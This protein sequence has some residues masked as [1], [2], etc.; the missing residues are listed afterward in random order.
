MSSNDQ[1]CHTELPLTLDDVSHAFLRYSRHAKTS[2]PHTG[3]FPKSKLFAAFTNQ[4]DRSLHADLSHTS[5]IAQSLFTL[6]PS[7]TLPLTPIETLWYSQLPS[8][9]QPQSSTCKIAPL[10]PLSLQFRANRLSLNSLLLMGRPFLPANFLTTTT[11]PIEYLRYTFHQFFTNI[12]GSAASVVSIQALLLAVGLSAVQATPAAAAL[13]WVLKDL[14]GNIGGSLL[15]AKFSQQ[16]DLQPR[17]GR[18]ASSLLYISASF[19]EILAPLFHTQLLL[20]GTFTTLL[21]N[22]SWILTAASRATTHVTF[23]HSANIGHITAKSGAQSTAA[24]V[25]GTT[26]GAGLSFCLS[27]LFPSPV[28]NSPRDDNAFD[29]EQLSSSIPLEDTHLQPLLLASQCTLFLILSGLSTYHLSKSLDHVHINRFDIQRFTF[30]FNQV[31]A[32]FDSKDQNTPDFDPSASVES[33]TKLESIWFRYQQPHQQLV[34]I[35]TGET[36]LP[37][38]LIFSLSDE[39]DHLN[40]AK[41]HALGCD[42][43]SVYETVNQCK[44]YPYYISILPPETKAG[45]TRINLNWKPHTTPKDQLY[46]LAHALLTKQFLLLDFHGPDFNSLA[47]TPSAELNILRFAQANNQQLRQLN[48]DSSYHQAFDMAAQL[49]YQ[50]PSSKTL[51]TVLFD[52]ILHFQ[53]N[54]SQPISENSPIDFDGII[55][56]S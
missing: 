22:I 47:T 45:T 54:T 16:F 7:T 41:L 37:S 4:V 46:A 39:Y 9:T 14:F 34:K 18:M 27:S 21:K 35:T 50:S 24:G 10:N 38:S 8:P 55:T 17:L 25:V 13:T 44:N 40:L 1:I 49:L 19:I 11:R 12:F 33:I 6:S 5:Q 52:Y 43:K 31:V 26:I 51:Q 30:F 53:W 23:S 32:I 36:S 3:V 2:Q 48:S 56:K 42:P 29:M 20:L 28:D 15:A